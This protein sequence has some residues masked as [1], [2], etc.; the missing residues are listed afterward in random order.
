MLNV[1]YIHGLNSSHH[2]FNY[3]VRELPPHNAICVDYK[4][5]QSLVASVF[6]VIKQIPQDEKVALVGHSL[7]GVI[8]SLIAGDNESRID[9]LVTISSPLGGSKA[10]NTLRWFPNTFPVLN[11]IV[12]RGPLITRCSSLNLSTPTLS[13]ISTGGH[14]PTSPERND[15]VVAVSSQKALKFAKHVEIPANHFEVL[16]HDKTVRELKDFLFGGTP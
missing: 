4:S 10:A 15:S 3:V 14:L 1:V 13:I 6:E 5:Q 11:D 2:S 8:A 16:V 9:K 7:G 12:P